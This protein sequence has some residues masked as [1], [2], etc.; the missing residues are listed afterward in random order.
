MGI[1][2]SG[3]SLVYR[4][5]TASIRSGNRVSTKL[6]ITCQFHRFFN[7]RETHVQMPLLSAKAFRPVIRP[8][9]PWAS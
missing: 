1:Q 4:I 9:A 8:S 5:Q 7:Q 3:R 2:T 6:N